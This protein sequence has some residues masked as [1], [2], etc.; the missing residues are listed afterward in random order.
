MKWISLG[1][2]LKFRKNAL[3]QTLKSQ[4]KKEMKFP[5]IPIFK[6]LKL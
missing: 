4:V 5:C 2:N 1:Q 3:G 6:K